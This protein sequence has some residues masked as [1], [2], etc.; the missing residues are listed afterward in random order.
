M[1][2]F[3]NVSKKEGRK[4]FLENCKL[5]VKKGEI[6]GILGGPKSGKTEILDMI[7]GFKKTNGGNIIVCGDNVSDDI[8]AA[9]KH[10]GYSAVLDVYNNF[11]VDTFLKMIFKSR[12]LDD[13]ETAKKGILEMVN[14]TG[15]LESKIKDLTEDNKKRLV[16]ASAYIGEPSVILLDNPFNN[17]D[18]DVQ[19]KLLEI[20]SKLKKD[21][22]TVITSSYPE[23]L[24]KICNKVLILTGKKE[25]IVDIE[26]M[27]K[28]KKTLKDV[29]EDAIKNAV[30]V[31]KYEK[32]KR[33]GSLQD[34]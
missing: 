6:L 25:Y 22:V 9:R 31:R 29:Q 26:D 1:L 19:N 23:L 11:N 18:E 27:V 13:E 4:H 7:M 21:R 17:I 32:G 2:K 14:F 16:L 8:L 3:D 20:I 30:S 10:L 5:E 33:K 12:E 28:K 15:D 34:K 24:E